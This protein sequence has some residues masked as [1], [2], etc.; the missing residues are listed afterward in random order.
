MLRQVNELGIKMNAYRAV[1]L[2][3]G[4]STSSNRKTKTV[5]HKIFDHKFWRISRSLC[6]RNIKIVE[7]LGERKSQ[8]YQRKYQIL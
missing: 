8:H 2:S 7:A 1:F 5:E 6:L 4:A 3:F